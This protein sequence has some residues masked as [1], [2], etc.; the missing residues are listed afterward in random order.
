MEG[1]ADATVPMPPTGG[2][3]ADVHYV[4]EKQEFSRYV[5]PDVPMLGPWPWPHYI[6]KVEIVPQTMPDFQVPQQPPNLSFLS[7]NCI[8]KGMLSTVLGKHAG[9]PYL[10]SSVGLHILLCV[11]MCDFV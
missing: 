7:E 9:V 4:P 3:G 6:P 11:L 2:S 5:K 1:P 10:G 8:A